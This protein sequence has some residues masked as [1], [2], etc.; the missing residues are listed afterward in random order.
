MEVAGGF[1]S[2]EAEV[3]SLGDALEA[4]LI[5]LDEHREGVHPAADPSEGDP[6]AVFRAVE[7]GLR[8][9]KEAVVDARG[10]PLFRL[11]GGEQIARVIGAGEAFAHG[12]EL[13]EHGGDVGGHEGVEPQMERNDVARLHRD[14]AVGAGAESD[15]FRFP[16]AHA[17]RRHRHGGV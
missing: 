10:H 15:E 2:F 4:L 1:L 9:G 16:F 12:H 8:A 6:W 7:A 11:T 3:E 17:R 13:F 5:T 14:A